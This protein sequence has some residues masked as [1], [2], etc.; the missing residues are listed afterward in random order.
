MM[1]QESGFSLPITAAEYPK[2][3][4]LPVYLQ[5][6]YAFQVAEYAGVSFLLAKPFEKCNLTV[7][8]KQR[9]QIESLTGM[10]CV[11][12]FDS[13]NWY[14]R[15]TML[16]EGIPFI[17]SD[18]QIF[19]PFLGIVLSQEKKHDLKRTEKLSSMSQHFL[20]MAIYH[21]WSGMTVSAAANEVAVSKMSMTRC[22]DELEGLDP[23]LIRKSGRSRLFLWEH[24]SADL[25][26]LMRNH[27]RNPV[28]RSYSLLEAL[29]ISD[30]KLGGLSAIA[31][32]TSLADYEYETFAV[33]PETEKDF[34][35]K[36]RFCVPEDERP[37]MLIQVIP[38][39]IEYAD[40]TAVDPLTAILS[41]SEEERADTR[42]ETA[43]DELLERCFSS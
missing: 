39:D 5:R 6:N 2:A 28:L 19:L 24:S 41:L 35:L 4:E 22:Y 31:H 12:V 14:A 34:S 15:D 37:A 16:K 36:S 21:G 42:I 29:D 9:L 30:K 10:N 18:R 11:F 25:W 43:V 17:L 23:S 26:K 33:S 8:R 3:S 1:M 27:F 13:L 20:L 40:G 7:L 32:Y 38:Y